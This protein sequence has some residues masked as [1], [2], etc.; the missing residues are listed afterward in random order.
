VTSRN[1]FSTIL[2][3]AKKRWYWL[4]SLLLLW[5]SCA[6]PEPKPAGS[7]L[8]ASVEQHQ[9]MRLQQ[10][11]TVIFPALEK[12]LQSGD[13]L[14]RLGT[15]ITSE[16]LRQMNQTDKRYSHCGIVNIEHDTVFVYHA[17]G[18]EFNP[19]QRIKREPLYSFCHP[20][21]NKAAAIVRTGSTA[22]QQ[23][24]IGQQ[25]KALWAQ[26]IPFD[27]AFDYQ[28]DDRLYCA[29]MV[30]KAISHVLQ[31]SSWFQFTRIN[32]KTFVAVDNLSA[33]PLMRFIQQFSY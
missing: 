4:P 1:N 20:S 26:G 8:P 24:Q 28:T 31:D 14:L 21:E 13:V 25:A 6:Q 3:N 5:Y 12:A 33:S 2:D 32:N 17:I 11:D 22:T 23:L 15:D 16:M 10:Y 18:G 27:M 30:S 29:E 19:D 7:S 9:T